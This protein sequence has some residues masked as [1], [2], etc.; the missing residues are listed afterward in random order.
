MANN[1]IIK[2]LEFA[3]MQMAAE[4]FLVEGVEVA[5]SPADVPGRL[6][7][8][9][10]HASRFTPV[11]ATQFTDNST[12][13]RVLAQYL[14]D[15]RVGGGSGFSGTL[16]E[17]RQTGKLTLSFRSTEFID[18]AVRDSKS[19]NDLELRQLGWAFGQIADMETWYGGIGLN[20]VQQEVHAGW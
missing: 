17:S 14:N 18:D 5:P 9:N 4:A 7:R 1:Q 12:G 10:T 8:G 20:V 16:F 2:L 13:F 6:R 15:P 19:T 3:N 11:Q